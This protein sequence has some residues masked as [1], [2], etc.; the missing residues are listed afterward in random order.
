MKS[1]TGTAV[2]EEQRFGVALVLPK[3]FDLDG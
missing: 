1:V 3:H 2:R